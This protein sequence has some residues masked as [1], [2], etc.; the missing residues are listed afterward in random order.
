MK[1]PLTIH[2]KQP[3]NVPG[4]ERLASIIA[5][6]VMVCN[7]ITGRKHHLAKMIAGG[8]LLYRGLSG[9]CN[10]Y[11]LIGKGN[12]PDPAKNVNIRVSMIVN[13]PRYEVYAYW[14]QLTNLPLFLKHLESV[15]P[16]NELHSIWKING[17]I[18]IGTIEWESAIVK[19]EPGALLSWSSVP[20]ASLEN[21]GK[22]TFEDAGEQQTQLDII[23][24]YRP[25]MGELGAGVAR[26]F[27]PLFE[28]MIEKDVN[29]FK[30]YIEA[31]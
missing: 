28:T 31:L 27:T 13:K 22:I 6:T 29:S 25:P 2:H 4:T 15:Q 19:D 10:L 18:G 8:Y 23:I 30:E 11:H 12:L 16:V 24:S 14:R 3:V 21:A 20:G 26:L 7:G 1:D 9:Y 5:G 17:P